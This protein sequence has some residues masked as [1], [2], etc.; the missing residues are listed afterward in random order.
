[1]KTHPRLVTTT[2][3][4]P[5]R[6]S[7]PSLRAWRCRLLPP[8][9]TGAHTHATR[10]FTR[11]PAQYTQATR[12]RRPGGQGRGHQTAGSGLG[13][14]VREH[15]LQNPGSKQSGSSSRATPP[16][17]CD[18]LA[19]PQTSPLA[20]GI[21][22]AR[23]SGTR[24]PT[25][26]RHHPDP[27]VPA[28][29]ARCHHANYARGEH[30]RLPADRL[31]P[32]APGIVRCSVLCCSTRAGYLLP[33]GVLSS[34]A[35]F[36]TDLF[37]IGCNIARSHSITCTKCTADGITAG[38][39]AQGVGACQLAEADRGD[40]ENSVR[41]RRRQGVEGRPSPGTPLYRRSHCSV[42]SASAMRHHGT[43]AAQ[44]EC[45]ARSRGQRHS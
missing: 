23:E 24:P 22:D 45:V 4:W 10:T 3:S 26:R 42:L 31:E 28:S 35:M 32:S 43:E 29:T 7:R 38:C 16:Q 41:V 13:Q 1:M 19:D 21:T 18:N 14:N 12:R 33:A 27:A 36:A 37:A 44:G 17:S 25:P 20:R 15:S 9:A 30:P 39:G 34:R 6:N 5:W 2:P 40:Q 8:V 11:T